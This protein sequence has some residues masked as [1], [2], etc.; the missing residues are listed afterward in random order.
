MSTTDMDTTESLKEQE[1]YVLARIDKFEKE[2]AGYIARGEP[3]PARID[4]YL[5]EY[6]VQL[7][8]VRLWGHRAMVREAE[9][10]QRAAEE[11][12]MRDRVEAEWRRIHSAPPLKAE[13]VRARRRE[14]GVSQHQLA[15]FSGVYVGTISKI[16]GGFD[17][18]K[19]ETLQLIAAGL[20]SL[21]EFKTPAKKEM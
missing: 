21:R 5:K 3:V 1:A 8:E 13:D 7:E 14:L 15:A 10:A 2:K 6:A 19:N 18:S 16:E 20:E 17:R 11:R 4:S 12:G 9:E